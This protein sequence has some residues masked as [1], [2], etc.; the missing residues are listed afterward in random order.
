MFDIISRMLLNCVLFLSVCVFGF[1]VPKKIFITEDVNKRPINMNG[2]FDIIVYNTSQVKLL[3]P[4]KL[5]N[6]LI[7][8]SNSLNTM[9]V[10]F[11]NVTDSNP[12]TLWYNYLLD[13]PEELWNYNLVSVDVLRHK[14]TAKKGSSLIFKERELLKMASEYNITMTELKQKE[15]ELTFDNLGFI[16]IR[17]GDEQIDKIINMVGVF[18]QYIFLF[19]FFSFGIMILLNTFMK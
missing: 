18:L 8:T 17:T 14:I 3:E 15:E 1:S 11:F 9:G 10:V 12:T 13:N 7:E 5:D 2:K 19:N 4:S 16:V 6:L